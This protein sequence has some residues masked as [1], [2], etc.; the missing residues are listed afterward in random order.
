MNNKTV[1]AAIQLVPLME[2]EK[3]LDLIDQA[4]SL[5]KSSGLKYEVGAFETNLEGELNSIFSLVEKIRDLAFDQD[6]EH[7]LIYL[8]MGFAKLHPLSMEA[9]TAPYRN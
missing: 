4:I 7:F 2:K 5:I 9:K 8:K 1:G 3:A 6:T